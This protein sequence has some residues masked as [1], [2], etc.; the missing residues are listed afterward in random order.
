MITRP[1]GP[2]GVPVAVIGQGTWRMG[3]ES[4]RRKDEVAALR[5]GIELGMTHVDTAEMY[6]EGGAERV[7]ATAI[8]VVVL[9]MLGDL[10][11]SLL[12]R[13][14]GVKDSSTLI[15]GHGGL[16]DRFDGLL[17]AALFM[18]LVAQLTPVPVVR[19]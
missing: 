15:P 16:M 11:E 17:G 10:F 4:G 8:A 3:E 14:A 18:L 7:V 9:G 6:G 19:F 12:K 1:F 13:S 5:L 2:T